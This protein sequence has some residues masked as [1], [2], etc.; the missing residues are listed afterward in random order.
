MKNYNTYSSIECIVRK[1]I[2][3]SPISGVVWNNNN[4]Y[5][6]IGNKDSQLVRIKPIKL[7][8]TACN[9]DYYEWKLCTT[10]NLTLIN[11]QVNITDYFLLLPLI[12]CV[13]QN[14]TEIQSNNVYY[15]LSSNW[16]ELYTDKN[17]K[18]HFNIK[19]T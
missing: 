8:R 16:K 17:N 9:A 4:F 6:V 1:L 14:R 5:I 11:E 19:L 2:M 10:S 12:H 13:N 7:I 15:L 3:K 18:I